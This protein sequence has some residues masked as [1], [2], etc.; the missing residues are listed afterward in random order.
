MATAWIGLIPCYITELKQCKICVDVW[1]L[2]ILE[3]A[4]P[5]ADTIIIKTLRIALGLIYCDSRMQIAHQLFSVWAF[6]MPVV[7]VT[8][9]AYGASK[10]RVEHI[11]DKTFIHNHSIP[12]RYFWTNISIANRCRGWEVNVSACCTWVRISGKQIH[13]LFK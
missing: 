10:R 5:N 9:P 12:H 11:L 4:N 1:I 13:I 6:V 3:V 2:N 8:Q 7:C